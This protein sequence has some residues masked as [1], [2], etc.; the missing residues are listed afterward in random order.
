MKKIII[1]ICA[2]CLFAACKKLSN[3]TP[4]FD[5]SI[6]NTNIKIGDTAKFVLSGTPNELVFY[7]GEP[8]FNFDYRD[9]KSIQGT[10]TL[11]IGTAL[12]VAGGQ[13]NSLHL[14]ATTDSLVLDSTSVV[15]A[16]WTEI[17]SRFALGTGTA[18]TTSSADITDL[19]STGHPLTLAWKYTGTT[20]TIQPTW[21]ILAFTVTTT[22][23]NGQVFTNTTITN[24]VALWYKVH[25]LSTPNVVFG[26]VDY[27]LGNIANPDGS[28]HNAI[29]FRLGS[30]GAYISHPCSGRS[31]IWHLS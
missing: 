6:A 29:T 14:M 15:K 3:P 20:G 22:T 10:T 23:A 13:T 28:G 1:F 2:A 11:T 25:V 4:V 16:N 30:R 19:A 18:T 12:T 8:G 5:A 7:S 17:T 26:T 31:D 9:R 24:T 21:S 27:K